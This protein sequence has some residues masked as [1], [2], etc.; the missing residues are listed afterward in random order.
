[1]EHEIHPLE[2][3]HNSTETEFFPTATSGDRCV[4]DAVSELMA[5]M[6]ELYQE[7]WS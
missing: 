3:P 4:R 7:E 5:K 6:K 2:C 1:M